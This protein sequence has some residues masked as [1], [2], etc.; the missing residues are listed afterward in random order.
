MLDAETG[1]IQEYHV[2]TPYTQVYDVTRD[3]HGDVWAGGMTSD[4]IYRLK[5]ETNQFTDYLLPKLDYNVRRVD[6][7]SSTNPATFWVG[8][9]HSPVITKLEALD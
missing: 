6:V 7:D 2:N 3:Q 9:D 5:P 4:I 1:D 8:D